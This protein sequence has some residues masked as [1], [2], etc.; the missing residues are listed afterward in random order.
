MYAGRLAEIGPKTAIMTAPK[1]PYTEAL[2]AAGPK[3][4][5]R[6]QGKKRQILAGEPPDLSNVPPGCVLHPRCKY[7][8][9]ICRPEAP[10]LQQVGPHHYASCHFSH[11]LEL[12]GIE[13]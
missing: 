6:Y 12:V 5:D 11:K 9:D 13:S 10:E 8:A 4:S 1:H 3:I 7:A 2:L